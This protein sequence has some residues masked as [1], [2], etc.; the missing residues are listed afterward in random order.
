MTTIMEN[1]E[2]QIIEEFESYFNEIIDVEDLQISNEPAKVLNQSVVATAAEWLPEMI[3]LVGREKF[4]QYGAKLEG[5]YGR[6]LTRTEVS[7]RLP[8]GEAS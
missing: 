2:A 4:A 8:P 1:K 6:G 7:L 3:V 5:M